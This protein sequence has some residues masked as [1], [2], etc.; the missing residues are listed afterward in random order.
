MTNLLT[1]EKPKIDFNKPIPEPATVPGTLSKKQAA[2]VDH[3]KEI[4]EKNKLPV[5]LPKPA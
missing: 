1:P 5:S 3:V 4:F 2:S